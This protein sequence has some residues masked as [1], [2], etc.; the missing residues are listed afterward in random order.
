MVLLALAGQL[1][2]QALAIGGFPV[3]LDKELLEE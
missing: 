1:L 2:G 3:V